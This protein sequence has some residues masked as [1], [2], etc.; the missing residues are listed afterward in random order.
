MPIKNKSRVYR[1]STVGNLL[2]RFE[3]QRK[4]IQILAGPRQSGKTFI[5]RQAMEEADISSHYATAD[6]PSIKDRLCLE[7]QWNTGRLL[8]KEKG[9]ALLVLDEI[10][11]IPGWSEIVKWLWDEDSARSAN[12]HVLLLGSSPL[13]LQK[14]MTD[15]V[16]ELRPP[17]IIA[18]FKNQCKGTDSSIYCP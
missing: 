16:N 5:A 11:K 3:E 7:Q 15:I 14:G 8:E 13:L 18:F 10:Q 4:F 6:E 17:R 12:L 1:R 2:A 9:K